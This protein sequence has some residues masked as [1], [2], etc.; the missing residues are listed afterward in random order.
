MNLLERTFRPF[1]AQG[2]QYSKTGTL[3]QGRITAAMPRAQ[4]GGMGMLP[5][6]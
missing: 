6:R 5:I 1:A 3:Q 2:G 4:S